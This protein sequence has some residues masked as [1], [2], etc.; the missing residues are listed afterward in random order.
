MKDC[1]GMR[2]SDIASILDLEKYELPYPTKRDIRFVNGFSVYH[3]ETY[4]WIICGIFP[5]HIAKEIQVKADELEIRLHGCNTNEDIDRWLTHPKLEAFQ[6]EY[7]K[8]STSLELN[9]FVESCEEIRD[10]CLKNDYDNCYVEYYH[11][12][13]LEGLKYVLD[14]IRKNDIHTTWFK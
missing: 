7:I 3:S 10:D 9:E 13:T 1:R 11:I 5:V 6:R 4:Y 8:G 2:I 12:D 14:I